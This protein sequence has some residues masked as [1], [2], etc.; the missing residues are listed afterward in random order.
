MPAQ[1]GVGEASGKKT[2]EDHGAKQCQDARVTECE[3]SG[4][5]RVAL[6][7]V[8]DLLER[9]FVDRAVMAD[10]LDAEEA[11]IGGEADFPQVGETLVRS[12]D[13]EVVRVLDD[14]V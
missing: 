2:E 14:G 11:S 1:V 13:G 10:S 4:V 8:M 5:L 7:V 9:V 3:C 6:N 12:S